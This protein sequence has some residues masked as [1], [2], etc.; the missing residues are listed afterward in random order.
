VSDMY[1]CIISQINLVSWIKAPCHFSL[2]SLEI[3]S[4]R[5]VLR[6]YAKRDSVNISS[7]SIPLTLF[8]LMDREHYWANNFMSV[9]P[10]F[11]S[12]KHLMNHVVYTKVT[13]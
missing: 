13:I 5:N 11:K 6:Q 4:I 3:L 7:I 12:Q 8:A 2:R 9:D 1:V 10:I